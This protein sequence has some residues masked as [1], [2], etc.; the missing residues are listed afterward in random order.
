MSL[1]VMKRLADACRS[2]VQVWREN[3]MQSDS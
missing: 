2:I 3:D 1:L